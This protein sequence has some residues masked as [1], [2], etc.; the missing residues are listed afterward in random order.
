MTGGRRA[1]GAGAAG[2]LRARGKAPRLRLIQ[3][4]SGNN[5]TQV[6][7][8]PAVSPSTIEQPVLLLLSASAT[9]TPLRRCVPLGQSPHGFDAVSVNPATTAGGRAVSRRSEM[10]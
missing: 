6:I 5:A 8:L 10:G 3:S 7:L 4:A 9:Q 1:V 2:V